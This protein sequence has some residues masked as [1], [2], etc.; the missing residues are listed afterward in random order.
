MMVE[1]LLAIATSGQQLRYYTPPPPQYHLWIPQC[2]TIVEAPHNTMPSQHISDDEGVN[3]E[4]IT[5]IITPV[6][7]TYTT[8]ISRRLPPHIPTLAA[9]HGATTFL[10]I[11]NHRSV[12]GR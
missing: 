3:G 1:A 5:T 4:Q 12:Y 2:P 7:G 8:Y 11:T 9:V 10:S 6:G